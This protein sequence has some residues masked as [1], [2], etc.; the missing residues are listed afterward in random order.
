MKKKILAGLLIVTSLMLT[1]CGDKKVTI[2][3]DALAK[4]LMT[5]GSYNDQLTEIDDAMA[6]SLYG[7]DD[8]SVSGTVVIMGTGATAEEI[9]V[10]EASSED[11]VD[12]VKAAVDK[13][14]EDQKAAC[15]NYLPNEMTMLNDP[16]IVTEGKYVILCLSD[17][18]DAAQ[19]IV[20]GYI[21]K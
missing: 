2:D 17:D 21:N 4:D 15:E 7:L 11:K 8:T 13:R 10:F 16:L 12:T 6:L 19:K 14:V 3:V 1:A 18:N 5:N 9:A 20:D